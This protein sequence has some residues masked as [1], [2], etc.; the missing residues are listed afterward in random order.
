LISVVIGTNVI[1]IGDRA[2]GSCTSLSYVCFEGNAPSLGNA[3]FSNDNNATINYLPGTTGWENFAQLTGLPTVLWNPQAQN[4][5]VQA[6]QFG[7]AITGSSNLTVMVE[8]CTNLANPIWSPV[9]TKTLTGGSA[10]FSDPQW[11]NFPSRFYQF[12]FP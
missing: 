8:A 12:T 1:H 10:Y 7:F 9:R 6:N 2:F 5:G 11:T 4:P 3:V